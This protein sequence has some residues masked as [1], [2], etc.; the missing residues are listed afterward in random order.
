MKET[1]LAAEEMFFS[2]LAVKSRD[3]KGRKRYEEECPFRTEFQRDRDRIIHCKAFRRLKNKTQVFIAPFGDHFRT[4]MTHTLEVTQIARSIAG[5][6]NLNE[7]LAEAIALGHDL[8]HTPFGHIGEKT[9]NRISEEGFR[10]NEQ[11]VRI[12]EVIEKN[13]EG[14]NLTYE[15]LD[16]ILNHGL[17]AHPSTAEGRAVLLADKIAY[18]NHD[19]DDALRA[20]LITEDMVPQ[21][22]ASILGKTTSAR[23]NNMIRAIVEESD[24]AGEVKMSAE[25]ENAMLEMRA[26]CFLLSIPKMP[27]TATAIKPICLWNFCTTISLN[28]LKR[29]RK[30][31]KRFWTDFPYRGWY[32]T[33]LRACRIHM[34]LTFSRS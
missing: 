16:G 33:I 25:V 32:A 7:D 3:T 14:L 12:V 22:A 6:L 2:P 34:P 13:G 27:A 26:F 20:G 21:S 30:N 23:I 19:L 24:R 28:T 10:H 15:V 29:C 17:S 11:S 18:I 5:A 31:I 4:R 9:L 8:G 1:K